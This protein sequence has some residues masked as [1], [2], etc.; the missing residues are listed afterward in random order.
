MGSTRPGV[1]VALEGIDGAGKTTQA[2]RLEQLLRSGGHDVLRTKEPTDGQWGRKLRESA[3]AGRLSAEEELDLFLR[4][5][6]E[7]VELEIAP[8]LA[9][10][11][12]VIVDRY[13][14]STVAYQGARGLDPVEIMARNEA[15]AP[16]PDLLVVLDVEPAVGLQRIGARGDT[17][18]AFEDEANLRAVAEQFQKLD[19]P[20]MIRV[21]GTEPPERITE[22]ILDVLYDG[23]LAS[24]RREV[25]AVGGRPF[26]NSAIWT[27][28]AR[29]VHGD[30]KV[31]AG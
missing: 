14:F 28:F 25:D 13:Y 7:H 31:S 27:E 4:D 8:A 19:L 2:A 16:K 3:T 5:R 1:L 30:T 26:T 22:G 21:D 12:V 18:N 6:A 17:A 23:P 29:M 20:Y 15:F 24:T 9:A 10:G 11:K